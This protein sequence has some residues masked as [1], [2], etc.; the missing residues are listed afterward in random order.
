VHPARSKPCITRKSIIQ[1]KGRFILIPNRSYKSPYK[2]GI[3]GKFD[4]DFPKRSDGHPSTVLFLD[5]ELSC[6]FWQ[7]G[8]ILD[9]IW[10]GVLFS[11]DHVAPIREDDEYGG[12]RAALIAKF[13][14]INTPLKIDITT[15]D[16]IT[17]EAI[18]YSFPSVFEEKQIEVWAYNIETT[19]A[20]K[21][22]TILRRSV[23]NTRPRDFYDVYILIKTHGQ[24]IHA[25]DF[26]S[27]L[28]A[29]VEKR[30]SQEALQNGNAILHTI[31]EDAIMRSHWNRY[32]Q[33]YY[34]ANGISFDEVIDVLINILGKR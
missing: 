26:Q 24:A 5:C 25:D 3:G 8:P 9:K 1:C 17:P 29:T 10:D 23:L 32:C 13:E 22:E 7:I 11:V 20:E 4:E 27:A 6:P 34:Y 19:L 16:L 15:G 12:F 33:E 28:S 31:Q 18:C 30:L 21:V 2:A 14:S